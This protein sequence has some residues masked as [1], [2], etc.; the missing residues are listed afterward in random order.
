MKPCLLKTAEK[1]IGIH[2]KPGP[3]SNPFV[4][5]CLAACG[6]QGE[7]DSV[8]PWCAC[9]ISELVKECGYSLPELPAAAIS[10]RHW[11]VGIEDPEI[12][13]LAVFPHHI[14]I[15]AD[16]D[17][18]GIDLLGGNQSDAVNIKRFGYDNV[19]AFRNPPID[20]GAM[21]A[22]SVKKARGL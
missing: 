3:G 5:K 10:W 14:G 8:I 15:V 20:I 22:N 16:F 6:Y 21:M 4:A 7:D 2:E 11:G 12:G 13:C 17:D 9:F 1:Y 18:D 19:V